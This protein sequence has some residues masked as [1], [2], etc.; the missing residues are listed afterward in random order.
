ML[1][2]S[3]WRALVARAFRVKGLART[4]A[5][6]SRAR[7]SSPF[8]CTAHSRAYC[9]RLSSHLGALALAQQVLLETLQDV[10]EVGICVHDIP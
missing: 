2:S 1:L 3:T 7:L 4:V 10:L 9:P 6:G 5:P 8:T